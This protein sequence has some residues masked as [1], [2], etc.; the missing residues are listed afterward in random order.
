M[1]FE[2]WLASTSYNDERKQ[3]LRVAYFALRGGRPTRWQCRKIKSF[4]K[5]ESYPEYKHCRMINSRSDFFKVFSGPLFKAIEEVVYQL[6]EFIKHVPVPERPGKVKE[7]RR[8]GRRYYSTD[9]T[10]FESHFL[11]EVM[12]AIE[13]ELYRHCLSWCPADAELICRTLKGRNDMSTHTGVHASIYGRRMSGDMCTSLGNGFT[14][15]MLAKFIASEQ[16]HELYGFVEGDDGL[17]ATEAILSEDKYR[18]LGFTIK[19]TPEDDPC[20]ASFCGM[21]FADSGEIVRD[22]TDYLANFAWTSSFI[23][24]GDRVMDELLRAK[25]LS[26]VYETPQCPIVGAVAR[27]ALS[28]TRHVRPRFVEDGYHNLSSVPRDE[29]KLPAFDPA[30]DTRALVERKFGISRDVQLEIERR[31]SKGD[32]DVAHLLPAHPHLH[33]YAARYVECG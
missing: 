13:L 7:L 12:D 25:A 5:T 26:S 31:V 15:L 6:P 27:W 18:E 21:V 32:F 20:A 3:E 29:S 2:E 4:V 9:F 24:A 17:F 22:P 28:Q 16:G 11:P 33:H 30:D 14:N 10:A 23:S 8:A 19:I 1:G